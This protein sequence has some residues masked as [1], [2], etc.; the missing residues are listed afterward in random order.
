M[1]K[2]LEYIKKMSFNSIVDQPETTVVSVVSVNQNFQFYSRLAYAELELITE[3]Y[4]ISLSI[5]QQISLLYSQCHTLR[6]ENPFNSIVDQL[7]HTLPLCLFNYS[8]AFNS[9]VD[10][11]VYFFLP[12]QIDNFT[13]NSIVDQPI[14]STNSGICL[15]ICFQ[16]YSRL[17]DVVSPPIGGG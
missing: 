9:I 6:Q 15:K 16:F 11:H 2:T 13:F 1:S 12:E 7:L 8:F 4:G 10:Q 5:L 17:A 14:K 3:K